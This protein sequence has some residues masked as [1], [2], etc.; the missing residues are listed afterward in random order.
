MGQAGRDSIKGTEDRLLTE[1]ELDSLSEWLG[2]GAG[3]RAKRRKEIE[4][5]SITEMEVEIDEVQ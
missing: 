2:D 4:K 1:E 3:A 5:M